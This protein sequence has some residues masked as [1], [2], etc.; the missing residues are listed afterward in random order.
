MV[1]NIQ[2]LIILMLFCNYSGWLQNIYNAFNKWYILEEDALGTCLK[3]V[4]AQKPIHFT[5]II[6]LHIGKGEMTE[7][8]V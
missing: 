2:T 7:A 1:K 4:L 3:S 6:C 5:S 8:M